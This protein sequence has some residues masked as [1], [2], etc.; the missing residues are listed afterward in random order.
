[1]VS[2]NGNSHKELLLCSLLGKTEEV[3]LVKRKW[4]GGA[5]EGKK[6]GVYDGV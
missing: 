3:R 2:R 4:G 6:A 1:M 5:V